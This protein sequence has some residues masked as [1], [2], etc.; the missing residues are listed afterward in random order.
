MSKIT[1]TAVVAFAL[2]G[3]S[4][5]VAAQM[6]MPSIGSGLPNVGSISAGNAAGVLQYCM[7]NKLVSSSSASTVL[8]GLTKSPN[9]TKSHDYT[10]GAAGQILGGGS[11]P[12]SIGSAPSY[13]QSRACDMVL[14]QGKHL[15]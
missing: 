3:T 13:L 14:K 2:A 12:F 6:H 4:Q 15:L 9:V 1:F 10:A 11:K 7:K 5:P 8:D